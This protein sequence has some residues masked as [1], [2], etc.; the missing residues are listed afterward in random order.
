MA[1]IIELGTISARGQIAIPTSI[2][3]HLNLEEGTKVLFYLNNN[4]L[5]IKKVMPK[6]FTEITQPM[7][8]AAKTAGITEKDLDTIMKKQRRQRH[9]HRT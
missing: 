8:E 5:I 1:D 3:K 4:T 2:R 6:T 9:E 7:K